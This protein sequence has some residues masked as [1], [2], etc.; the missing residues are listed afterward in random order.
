MICN[1]VS[2]AAEKVVFIQSVPSFPS[3]EPLAALK[4]LKD[5]KHR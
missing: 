5:K 1:N 2:I 3:V 4:T